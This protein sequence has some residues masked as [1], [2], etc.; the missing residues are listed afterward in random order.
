MTD[1]HGTYLRHLQEAV[2]APKNFN[3]ALAGRYGTGK[4]SV[5]DRFAALN[6]KTTMRIAISTPGP[7]WLH[8]DNHRPTAQPA[9]SRRSPG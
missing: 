7:D 4:S 1:Q 6:K 2:A 5:L 8:F 3:I 9:A